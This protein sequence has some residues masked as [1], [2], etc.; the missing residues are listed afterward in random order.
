MYRFAIIA[1]VLSI[2]VCAQARGRGHGGHYRQS[3]PHPGSV[4]PL[5]RGY[6]PSYIVPPNYGPNY[7]PY[8]KPNRDGSQSYC[9]GGSGCG[10]WHG[11]PKK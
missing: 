6:H 11:G 1:I 10:S 9:N 4:G 3:V 7:I 2:S 5:P 8:T